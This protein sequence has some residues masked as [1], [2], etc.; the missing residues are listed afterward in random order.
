MV[1]LTFTA[2]THIAH[3]FKRSA[4][5]KLEINTNINTHTNT[6]TNTQTHTQIHTI[7]I[8]HRHKHTQIHTHTHTHTQ[9]GVLMQLFSCF[10]GKESNLKAI[11]CLCSTHWRLTVIRN[12]HKSFPDWHSTQSVCIIRNKRALLFKDV[13]AA[14]CKQPMNLVNTLC[15]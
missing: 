6:N 1:G 13:V 9:K 11:A 12:I 10:E 5:A 8:T 15:W 4:V 2:A 14:Y 3:N 7:T